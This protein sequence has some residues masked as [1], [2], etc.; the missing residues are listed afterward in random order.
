MHEGIRSLFFCLKIWKS[1]VCRQQQQQL[2]SSPCE[3][4]KMLI[5][6]SE[7]R[8]RQYL[9]L[10]PFV[11]EKTMQ[12]GNTN[13]WSCS[14]R[15]H[16]MAALPQ[17]NKKKWILK[18]VQW[19]NQESDLLRGFVTETGQHYLMMALLRPFWKEKKELSP[20]IYLMD[21]DSLTLYQREKILRK[22]CLVKCDSSSRLGWYYVRYFLLIY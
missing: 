15:T 14:D 5:E 1:S 9:L 18:Q 11:S 2:P 8:L 7:M 4:P 16:L 10:S 19:S 17:P 6:V 22:K 13:Q 3:L 12:I 21:M 20:R